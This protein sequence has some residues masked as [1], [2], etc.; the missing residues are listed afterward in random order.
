MGKRVDMKRASEILAEFIEKTNYSELPGNVV[1]EVKRRLL[2]VIGVCLAGAMTDVGRKITNFVQDLKSNDEATIIGSKQKASSYYAALANASMG[3]HLELDDVHRTSHTH[4]GITTIPTALALGEKLGSSGRELIAAINAG[5]ETEI[6]I[7]MALSPSIFLDRVFLPCSLLGSFGAGATAC[8]LLRLGRTE[9]D[10]ALGNIA[11]LTPISIFE[12]YKSGTLAKEFMMG[13]SNSVGITSA[14]MT[15][16]DI[17]G[18]KLAIEGTLGFAKAAADQY[19]LSR[20]AEDDG[21]SSGIKNTGIKPYACCRQHH[22]A[23]DATLELLNKH[24]LK[25]EEIEK[26]IDRTFSVATR[27]NEI[28]PRTIAEAKY[29]APYVI[30]V[31]LIEG[32]VWREQ[33]TSEKIKDPNLLRLAKKVEVILDPDLDKLYDQKWPSIVEVWTTDG[34]R[35][36]ARCDLPKG[37]PEK[38]LTDREIQEKFISLATDKIS[39][40]RAKEIV[41]ITLN[42]EQINDVRELT[43]L[44]KE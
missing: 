30:S 7:G 5:Y 14:L 8:K 13:W 39:E 24:T 42:I 43:L 20:I 23:V 29:S 38:P 19:D 4:P 18:P 28:A 32:K 3:F 9:I 40:K 26:I 27:G 41:D 2:D 22:T 37:E 12:S 36:S 21:F 44:F 1:N 16:N 35:L 6:R 31:A 11:T 15:K 17:L 33:F 34:N 10:G 25:P